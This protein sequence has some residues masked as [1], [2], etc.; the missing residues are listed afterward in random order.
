MDDIAWWYRSPLEGVGAI[1]NLLAFWDEK[2]DVFVDGVKEDKA[3]G[4]SLCGACSRSDKI[5]LQY[6]E[7]RCGTDFRRTFSK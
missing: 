2:V 7:S 3:V 5:G 1:T 4:Q 6:M